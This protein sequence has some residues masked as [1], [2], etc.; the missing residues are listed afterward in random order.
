MPPYTFLKRSGDE[1]IL[2]NIDTLEWKCLEECD[3]KNKNIIF[4]MNVWC[5]VKSYHLNL[6]TELKRK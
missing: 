5:R 6:W 1:L 3:D 2:N 4:P